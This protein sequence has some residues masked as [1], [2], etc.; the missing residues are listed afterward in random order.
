MPKYAAK[1]RDLGVQLKIAEHYL[2]TIAVDYCNHPSYSEQCCKAV[3]QKWMES[4]DA[5][6]DMLQTAIDCLHNSPHDGMC[7]ILKQ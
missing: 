5:T 4:T 2:N 3:L 7:I 1:W 6:W